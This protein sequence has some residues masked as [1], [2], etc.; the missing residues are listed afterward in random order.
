MDGKNCATM[1]YGCDFT[2]FHGLNKG[3]F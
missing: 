1:E 3:R 2:M